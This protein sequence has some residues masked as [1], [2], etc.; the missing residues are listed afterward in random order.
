MVE[1]TPEQ[2][3]SLQR[4]VE[5]NRMQ[6]EYLARAFVRRKKESGKGKGHK[7]KAKVKANVNLAN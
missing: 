7:G 5:K 3:Y 2:R 4:V 6:E 1:S